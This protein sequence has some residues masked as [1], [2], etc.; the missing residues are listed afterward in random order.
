MCWRSARRFAGVGA[1]E[2]QRAGTPCFRRWRVA[3][4]RVTLD[5]DGDVAAASVM[6]AAIASHVR[7]AAALV[8]LAAEF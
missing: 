8:G 7:A 2:H 3:G 1:R 6:E 5:L 4:R